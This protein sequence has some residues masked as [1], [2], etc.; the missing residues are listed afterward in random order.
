MFKKIML[1]LV[2]LTIVMTGMT[3]NTA[4]AQTMEWSPVR[5]ILSVLPID[6]GVWVHLTGDKIVENSPCMN[7]FL[8]HETDSNY[9]AKVATILSAYSV[10]GAA[11]VYFDTT[12]LNCAVPITRLSCY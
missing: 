4:M 7:R 6:D 1:L 5:N 12:S 10:G 2:L 8:I 3:L 9:H 11:K